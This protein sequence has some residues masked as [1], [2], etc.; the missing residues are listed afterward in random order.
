MIAVSAALLPVIYHLIR[1]MRARKVKFSSLLFLRATPKELIKKRRLRDL[2]LLI[3]RSA[4]FALLALAFARPFIPRD[5][6]PFAAQ[7]DL[8]SVVLLID[9]SYSMQYGDVFDRVRDEARAILEDAGSG[10]EYA[11]VFFSDI[12]EQMTALS[13]DM[14]VHRNTV[15]NRLTVSFRP[16]DFYKPLRLA[17]DILKDAKNPGRR[18]IMLSDFQ[19]AGWSSQ[20]DNWKLDPDITFMPVKIAAGAAVNTN[21]NRFSLRQ[22]RVGGRNAAE[23]KVA[24]HSGG[25]AAENDKTVGLWLN[26]KLAEQQTITPGQMN[27][28][29]FQQRDIRNGVYQGAVKT[30]G[31]ALSADDAYYFTFTVDELPAILCVDDAQETG[32]NDAFF[33]RS[34][35]DLGDGSLYRITTGGEEYLTAGR[36]KDFQLVFLT[37]PGALSNRQTGALA[38]YVERGGSLVVSFGDRVDLRN[39]A[40]VLETLGIGGIAGKAVL[41]EQSLRNAVIGEVDFKHPIFSVFVASGAGELYRPKFREYVKIAPDSGAAVIGRYDTG[42]PFLVERRRGR[43]T[44]LAYSSTFN[45]KWS[46]FPVNEIYV[47]FLYQLAGYAAARGDMRTDYFVG[48]PLPLKGNP[49]DEWEVSAPGDRLFKVA[50]DESG[51]GYFRQTGEPGNYAAV[52]GQKQVNFSVNVDIRE[53]DLQTR[54]AEEAY[55]LITR[56]AE[57]TEPDRAAALAGSIKEDEKRQKLWRYIVLLIIALFAFETYFANRKIPVTPDTG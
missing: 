51:T 55:A 31:D 40:R 26:G 17:E 19:N 13:A 36:L 42:D 2:I 24:L 5:K 30:G 50:V 4:I 56:P 46:D 52:S 44:V 7:E 10:D 6:I 20:F 57:E 47:P 39:A 21:I 28:A 18:I 53:S 33:L 11:V 48:A 34:V 15:E 25:A 41:R 9:N 16:T 49:G 35:F 37:N 27:Q 1:K 45:T 14:P 38:R 3:V 54:D 22:S 43:G 29:F 12:A 32:R 8:K 23:Y